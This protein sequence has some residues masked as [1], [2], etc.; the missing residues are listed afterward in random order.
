MKMRKPICLLLTVAMIAAVGLSGCGG[1]ADPAKPANPGA[2]VPGTSEA[3][4]PAEDNNAAI[5]AD[6]TLNIRF[7]TPLTLDVNDVRNVS[8]FQALSQVQEALV[9]SFTDEN[10]IERV[11]PA[12]AESWT[13][14][15]DGLT[16]TFKIREN[17]WSDGVPVVAQHYADSFARILDPEKAFSYAFLA[18]D[19]KNAEKY[20]TQQ[21]AILRQKGGTA[22]TPEEVE[23]IKDPVAIEDVGIKAPDDRTLV[24]TLEKVTPMFEKKLGFTALCPIRLDVIAKGDG[25]EATDFKQQVY[26][27]PFVISDWVKE[28]SMTLTKNP[29]FWDAENVKLET[30]N[31]L[32]AEELATRALLFESKQLDLILGEQEYG[33]KWKEMATK[34]DFRYVHG[35]FP[36]VN[37]IVYNH[38][39]AGPSGLMTNA[40]IKKAMSLAIDRQEFVDL[41]YER[42][43]PAY[44]LIPNG[45]T[46]G[47]TDYRA[48][49]EE[50][51]KAQAEEYKN[52]TAKL[53]ALFQEG[54]KE[55][56]VN[57]PLA[58]VKL[59]MLSTGTDS[60]AKSAMEYYQQNWQNKLGIQVE[61]KVMESKLF[62]NERNKNNYDVINMGW[63]GDY[64]DPLT[65]IDMWIT[66]GGFSKFM[67]WYSSDVYDQKLKELANITDNAERVKAY[68]ELENQLVAVDYG[69]APVYY[70]DMQTFVHNYVKNISFPLFGTPIE[71]SRAYISGK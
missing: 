28:N 19:L 1:S 8:E 21:G 10:N 38:K 32:M 46:V 44:G 26:C 68:A 64:N 40:K 57:M 37:Y 15:E 49:V 11:E 33:T 12:G 41:I 7:T 42:Y 2:A 65:F 61:L 50:P 17:T 53:Q 24:L 56:G 47:D 5:D 63:N 52:D 58:D 20:Y 34:G 62:A 22:L 39:S 4:K 43:T 69:V 14:S 60:T 18:Y 30:V 9:R 25:T 71:F 31:M 27:G 13:V 3:A 23:L 29:T 55:V 51:L 35:N 59:V 48:T 16:W 45:M 54:M 66:N 36:S 70:G 67:G 6:Q